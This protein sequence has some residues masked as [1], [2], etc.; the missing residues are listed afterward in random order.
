MLPI[1]FKSICF[2]IQEFLYLPYFKDL[3][4]KDRSP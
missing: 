4:L 3:G 1:G 2:G